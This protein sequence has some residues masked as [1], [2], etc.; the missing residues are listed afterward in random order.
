MR[1]ADMFVFPSRYEAGPLVILEAM[2][3]GLPIVTAVT[4]GAADLVGADCG[5]V[6]DDP[7]NAHA[8]AA[9]LNQ[10]V[11]YPQRRRSMGPAGREVIQQCCS[12]EQMS[13]RYLQLYEEIAK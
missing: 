2:A 4:A 7:D 6:I 5:T 13:E 12:W 10:L 11:Q 3:S 1:A 9:A 8:L